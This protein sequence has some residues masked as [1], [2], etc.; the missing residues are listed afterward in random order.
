MNIPIIALVMSL[1]AN[2]G[3]TWAYLGQRDSTI[4]ATSNLD[5]ATEAAKSCSNSVKDMGAAAHKRQ[6]N[7]AVPRAAAAASA[8]QGNKRADTILS[9][10]ATAPGNDC[11][12]VTDRANNWFKATP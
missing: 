11:K 9:T 2:A 6:A 10:P 8:V 3:L 4:E 12:S 7:A 5:T 1:A